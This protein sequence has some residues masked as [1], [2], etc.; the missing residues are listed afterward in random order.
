MED[1]N[2]SLDKNSSVYSKKL[3]DLIEKRNKMIE[4]Q[5]NLSR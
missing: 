3:K 4:K 1:D 5:M 2:N